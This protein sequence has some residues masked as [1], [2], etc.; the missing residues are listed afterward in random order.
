MSELGPL[1]ELGAIDI[2]PNAIARCNAQR[3]LHPTALHVPGMVVAAG[4]TFSGFAGQMLNGAPDHVN[5][6]IQIP[7]DD[8]K[9]RYMWV[10]FSGY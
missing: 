5:V 2:A 6:L 3:L 8:R 10:P 9:P 4:M 7:D 1:Q